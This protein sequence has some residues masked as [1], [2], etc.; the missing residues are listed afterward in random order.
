MEDNLDTVQNKQVHLFT[1]RVWAVTDGTTLPQWR[2]RLQNAQ[3]GEVN[4]FKD[5]E[6]L[7]D[8]ITQTL[9]EE[10]RKTASS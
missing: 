10:N 2:S 6:S 9:N 8:F 7:Q 1:L 3:S 4:F 5:L